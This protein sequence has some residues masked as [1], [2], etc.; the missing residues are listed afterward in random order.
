MICS[1]RDGVTKLHIGKRKAIPWLIATSWN[2]T[3]V[4]IIFSNTKLNET[5]GC[6]LSRSHPPPPQDSS[7]H[8]E[9]VTAD[10]T[11]RDL[12]IWHPIRH[13]RRHVRKGELQL[14]AAMSP[15]DLRNLSPLARCARWGR[16]VLSS[17]FIFTQS[18]FHRD[19]SSRRQGLRFLFQ[20]PGS[21]LTASSFFHWCRDYRCVAPRFVRDRCSTA[22]SDRRS[23][24]WRGSLGQTLHD[25][26]T[27]F[28]QRDITQS[29]RKQKQNKENNIVSRR[30]NS[31]RNI[32][33]LSQHAESHANLQIKN[34]DTMLKTWKFLHRTRIVNLEYKGTPPPHFQGIFPREQIGNATIVNTVLIRL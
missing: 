6:C 11:F 19:F 9:L 33:G 29:I 18:W 23:W 34:R 28:C 12:V 15:S 13:L 32:S 1:S 24:R 4:G 26:A 8:T 2:F 14:N 10:D 22:T 27:K 17:P 20:T 21:K 16:L 5:T 7:Y 3:V 31:T 25:T 30:S